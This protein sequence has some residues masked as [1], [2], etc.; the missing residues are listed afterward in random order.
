MTEITQITFVRHGMVYNPGNIIYG[1]LPRFGLSQ[2][3][4]EDAQRAALALNDVH[5]KALYSSPLL[6]ARQTAKE[7]SQFHPTL[8]L[9][10]SSLITE[11]RT[12]HEGKSEA[13]LTQSAGDV[14]ANGQGKGEQPADI[15]KRSLEFIKRIRKKYQGCHIAAVSHGDVILFLQLWSVGC[16]ITPESKLTLKSNNQLREYPATGSLTT[17]T[18]CSNAPEEIP[19]FNYLNTST[20]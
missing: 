5:L 17:F 10:I 13:S 3:G 18:Y 4:I 6:R 15:H 20:V 9:Q 2:Q 12:V 7:I 11:V 1:R 14:Y 16:A 19:T 8:K